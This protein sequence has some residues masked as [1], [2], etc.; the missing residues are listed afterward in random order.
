VCASLAAVFVHAGVED[1][2]GHWTRVY[3]VPLVPLPEGGYE[4]LL[5]SDV[6]VFTFFWTEVPWAHGLPGHWE[7]GPYGSRVF[8]AEAKDS[9]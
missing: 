2:N 9:E 8:R 4:A 5:P 7:R 6:N 1:A 3:K